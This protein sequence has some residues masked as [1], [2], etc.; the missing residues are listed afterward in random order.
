MAVEVNAV[1][2][3]KLSG[4]FSFNVWLCKQ[5]ETFIKILTHWNA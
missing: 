4:L 1:V 2:T 5:V 3:L